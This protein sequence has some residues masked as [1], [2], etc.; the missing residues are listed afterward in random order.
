MKIAIPL[1]ATAVMAL[2]GCAV[3]EDVFSVFA[4]NCIADPSKHTASV[5]WG[6]VGAFDIKLEQDQFS[7]LT[8]NLNKGQAYVFRI[9]NS[10]K[11]LRS[12]EAEE[13]FRSIALGGVTLG[14]KTHDTTCINALNIA[15]KGSAELRFVAVNEGQFTFSNNNLLLP[16]TPPIGGAFGVITVN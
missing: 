7:P 14:G 5:D 10:E 13:F 16:F 1:L 9:R 2:S 15:S 4:K 8:I 12:F 11:Y 6:K 3:Q